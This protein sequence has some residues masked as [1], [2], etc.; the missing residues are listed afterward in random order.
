VALPMLVWLSIRFDG[1][2]VPEPAHG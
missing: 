1:V 2:A